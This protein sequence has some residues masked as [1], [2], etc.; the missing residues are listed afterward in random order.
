MYV[1]SMKMLNLNISDIKHS[2][3]LGHYEN[4]N[5]R[6][7][8]IEDERSQ[9]NGQKYISYKIGYFFSSKV[10]P[11]IS[12]ISKHSESQSIKIQVGECLEMNIH[13]KYFIKLS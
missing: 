11:N 1:S 4:T 3:K 6:I 7:I 2:G 9:C 5:L 13:R 8:G 12:K 10:I